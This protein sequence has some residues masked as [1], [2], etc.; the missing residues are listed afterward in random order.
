M[1]RASGA[2]ERL[3]EMVEDAAARAPAWVVTGTIT[4]AGDQD[5][6]NVELQHPASHGLTFSF[7]AST[8]DARESLRQGMQRSEEIAVVNAAPALEHPRLVLG[9]RSLIQAFQ[10]SSTEVRGLAFLLAEADAL[11]EEEAAW[12]AGYCGTDAPM[13]PQAP[14]RHRQVAVAAGRSS[15]RVT[16]GDAGQFG[17]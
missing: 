2:S 17:R 6:L 5:L 16:Y 4:R 15:R 14:E 7:A 12:L 11:N 9:V 13:S 10:W 1:S 3:A 8:T